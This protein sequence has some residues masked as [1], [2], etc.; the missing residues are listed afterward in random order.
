MINWYHSL[1]IN[2]FNGEKML[3]EKCTNVYSLFER[4][5]YIPIIKR[6]RTI[7]KQLQHKK[8]LSNIINEKRDYYID[9]I[10][11]EFIKVITK[12]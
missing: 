10:R 12:I 8:E 7:L 6:H 2:N 5:E 1:F 9:K 4:D 11:K 3:Y